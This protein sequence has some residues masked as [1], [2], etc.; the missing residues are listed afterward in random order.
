MIDLQKR[1]DELEQ[2]LQMVKAELAKQQEPDFPID[3][4]VWQVTTTY[5]ELPQGNITISFMEYRYE[6]KPEAQERRE[7]A[8]ATL[9]KILP[10]GCK[11]GQVVVD[12]DGDFRFQENYDAIS[13]PV[14]FKDIVTAK[15]AM[16]LIADDDA[17]DKLQS[18]INNYLKMLDGLKGYE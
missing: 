11:D 14:R 12:G 17:E 2:E 10:Y 15:Y 18:G 16:T 4:S 13:H 1:V 8:R 3:E 5:K 6:M 9:D 7:K